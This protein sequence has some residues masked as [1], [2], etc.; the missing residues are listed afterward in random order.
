[1]TKAEAPM[2]HRLA[3]LFEIVELTK[4]RRSASDQTEPTH[5]CPKPEFSWFSSTT[6]YLMFA[7][8]PVDSFKD[9]VLNENGGQS[10]AV[11]SPYRK[12]SQ[13]AAQ[14]FGDGVSPVVILGRTRT[15][16]GD[17]RLDQFFLRA[18]S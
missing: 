3:V 18:G 17:V 13:V 9:T 1:M 10:R 7:P 11:S 4:H 8:S 2:I 14:G 12:H 16:R 6:R 15:D 5:G